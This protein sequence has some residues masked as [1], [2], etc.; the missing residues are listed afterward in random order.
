MANFK[1]LFCGHDYKL[2]NHF[3]IPSE[4]DNI[5]EKGLIPTTYNNN[6]RKIVSDFKCE[7][8]KKNKRL[9]VTTY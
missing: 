6:K 7:V 4:V 3:T 9:I 2:I 8:C 1:Q 5:R